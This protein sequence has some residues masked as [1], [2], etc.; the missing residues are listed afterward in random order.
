[1]CQIAFLPCRRRLAGICSILFSRPAASA[2]FFRRLFE[3]NINQERSA[4]LSLLFKLL[5]H[6]PVDFLKIRWWR[7]RNPPRC[8]G[9]DVSNSNPT[10]CCGCDFTPARVCSRSPM[11]SI[12]PLPLDVP[13]LSLSLP[14]S[15]LYAAKG[16]RRHYGALL[17]NQERTSEAISQVLIYLHPCL[18]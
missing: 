3:R 17:V 2:N 16:A 5:R 8:C 13:S 1:M 9:C 18:L 4:S 11:R 15:R 12:H 10:C 14:R 7:I 6:T